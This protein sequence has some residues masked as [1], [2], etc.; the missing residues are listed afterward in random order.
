MT[1]SPQ[2]YYREKCGCSN[3]KFSGLPLLSQR[4]SWVEYNNWSGQT[5]RTIRFVRFMYLYMYSFV[6]AHSMIVSG[7]MRGLPLGH[8][9]LMSAERLQCGYIHSVSTSTINFTSYC[10]FLLLCVFAIWPKPKLKPNHGT[11][12]FHGIA[13]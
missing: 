5:Q 8:V 9:E 10:I 11:R 6:K 2:L 13:T 12:I 7:Y 3:T 1:Q 4:R